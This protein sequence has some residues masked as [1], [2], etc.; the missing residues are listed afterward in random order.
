MITK[1][2]M[3]DFKGH[4]DYSEYFFKGLTIIS[5]TNNSGKTSLLQAVYL[6]T[7]NKN[8]GYSVLSVDEELKLGTFS[9][10]LNK[11]KSNQNDTM[12]FAITFDNEIVQR[13]GMQWITVNF[14]YKSPASF[15]NVISY[16]E[17]SPVLSSIEIDY[18]KN[19]EVPNNL[20]FEICDSISSVRNKRVLYRVK[21]EKDDG[22]CVLNGIIPD[23]VVYLNETGDQR[24]I[25]SY[26]FDVIRSF[27]M[28]LTRDNIKYLKA[29]RLNDFIDRNNSVFQDIGISGEYTAE[30]LHSNWDNHMDFYDKSDN[31]IKL[32]TLFDNW[33]TYFLGERYRIKAEKIDKEKYK[34]VINDI[35]R[36]IELSLNQVGFGISQLL[37]IIV[38]I[39]T[40]KKEDI[41]LIENPEVHLHPKLQAFFIDLCL[42]AIN[43]GRKIIVET[44]SEHIIN[45]IRLSIKKT[46]DN[47]EKVNIIFFEN[48][49]TGI[50][51]TNIELKDDGRISNWPQDFFDQ[52]YYD[53]LGLI[54]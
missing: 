44:H 34:I 4:E 39:L 11:S 7:Q 24:K 6:L 38:L 52:S 41:I 17:N 21:G 19:K 30:M 20:L 48:A 31:P 14:I 12:E 23:S 42:F 15:E 47:L 43:N 54:E 36:S 28:L 16:R 3:K 29:F 32:S 5:G 53:L 37:P 46:K 26:E 33:I 50:K 35:Q 49:D 13:N 10:I 8:K 1:F 45:R 22:F 2:E 9:D 27:L 40:S 25:C 51:H 18:Q